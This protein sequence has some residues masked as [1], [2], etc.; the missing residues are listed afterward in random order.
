MKKAKENCIEEQRSEIEENLRK[1]SKEAYQLMKDLTTVKQG[2]T[3]TSTVGIHIPQRRF[4]CILTVGLRT[5]VCCGF[6]R[7]LKR[8]ST[9]L[10]M[11]TPVILHSHLNN[12]NSLSQEEGIPGRGRSK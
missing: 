12:Y 8:L 3:T 4:T 6:I 10:K 1:N 11:L 9:F 7:T 5:S 2:T